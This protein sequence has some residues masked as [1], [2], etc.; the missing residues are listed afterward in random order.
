MI[1]SIEGLKSYTL[2]NFNII[3]KRV[4]KIENFMMN[5]YEKQKTDLSNNNNVFVNNHIIQD[6]RSH[7]HMLSPK[8]NKE[9]VPINLMNNHTQIDTTW[10]EILLNL[11]VKL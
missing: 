5:F 7:K 3:N 11:K 10:N 9:K 4:E 6:Q 8:N 2:E 1:D